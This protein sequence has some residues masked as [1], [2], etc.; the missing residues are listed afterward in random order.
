MHFRWR[1]EVLS[2]LLELFLSCD[3]SGAEQL[4]ARAKA[5]AGE[6][7]DFSA[8]CLGGKPDAAAIFEASGDALDDETVALLRKAKSWV[9]LHDWPEW[10]DSPLHASVLIA[11]LESGQVLAVSEDQDEPQP[12]AE[13]LDIVLRVKRYRTAGKLR[14]TS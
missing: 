9:E 11:L 12:A 4:L 14:L 10:G 1:G 3:R 13:L 8:A 6:E 5:A 7:V 2:V